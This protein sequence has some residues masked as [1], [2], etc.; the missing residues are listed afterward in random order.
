MYFVFYTNLTTTTLLFTPYRQ[1]GGLS[2]G[3]SRH[4]S[5]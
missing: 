4:R 5:L 1:C 3:S 2:T